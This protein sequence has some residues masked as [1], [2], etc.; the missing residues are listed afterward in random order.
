MQKKGST[1]FKIDLEKA[2]DRLNWDFLEITLNDFGFPPAT[3][4]FITS[5]VQ[6]SNL[7][8]LWNGAKTDHFS[9][10][11]GIRQGGPLS[12]CLFVLCMEKLSLSIQ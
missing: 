3:I 9:P 8:V 6:S 12:P 7:N 11:R 2:Y 4:S 10:S 5:C 1:A